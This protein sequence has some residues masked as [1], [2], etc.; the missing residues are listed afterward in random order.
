MRRL[1][2]VVPFLFA[3]A[4]GEDAPADSAAMAAAPAALTDADVSGTWT[5]TAMGEA[6][7]TSTVQFTINCG[8]G[9]CKLTTSAAPNDTIH[10][11][12]VLQADSSVGTS[13]PYADPQ[14]KAMV[15]D[16]YVARVSAGTVSGNGWV[17][18]ADKPDS[19]VARYRYSG[20]KAP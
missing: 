14:S 4:K 15:V 17:T 20:T 1:L 18:L 5:G 10:F 9:A 16:H 7:D 8:T 2:L 19:V 11:T 6:P 13:T 12:Y 3:C